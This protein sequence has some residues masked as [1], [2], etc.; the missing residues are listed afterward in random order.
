MASATV[1]VCRS[2]C[3]PVCL[4]PYARL[5]LSVSASRYVS[6]SLG[7]SFFRQ[8]LLQCHT[9]CRGTERKERKRQSKAFSRPVCPSGSLSLRG[10]RPVLPPRGRRVGKRARRGKGKSSDPIA[11]VWKRAP[12]AHQ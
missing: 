8:P 7:P 3:L 10:G 2:A 9:Q 1:V 6:L 4:C 11:T 5:Y 12:S